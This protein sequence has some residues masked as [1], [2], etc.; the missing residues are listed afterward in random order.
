MSCGTSP[1]VLGRHDG[2]DPAALPCNALLVEVC[3]FPISVLRYPSVPAIWRFAAP[4]GFV[5]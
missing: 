4:L 3:C 1:P 5:S 2:V